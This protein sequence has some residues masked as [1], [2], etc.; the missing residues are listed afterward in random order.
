VLLASLL[1]L[2]P[3]ASDAQTATPDTVRGVIRSDSGRVILGASVFVTRSSDRALAQAVTDSAGRYQVVFAEGS[4]D[5]LVFASAPGFESARRRVVRA[6][7]ERLLTVDLVLVTTVAT[8]LAAVQVVAPP[9]PRAP[10]AQLPRGAEEVGAADRWVDGPTGLL[11]P[12]QMGTIGAMVTTAPGFVASGGAVSYLG[13]P[14][15]GNLA[16]LNG[17]ALP[18]DR[19]PRLAQYDTRAVGSSFDPTSGGFA[20]AQFEI[21]L[22]PG[23][24]MYQRRV[25]SLALEPSPVQVTDLTGRAQGLDAGNLRASMAADGELVRRAMTYNVA[26][27][28]DRRTATPATLATASP[29]VL[30]LAGLSADSAQR[31]R[32]EAAAIGL[33]VGRYAPRTRTGITWLGRIDD[34]RDPS[35]VLALTTTLSSSR[36]DGTPELLTSLPSTAS[37]DRDAS[38]SAQL[39]F[40]RYFGRERTRSFEARLAYAARR[41]EA[42]PALSVPTATVLVGA[43]IDGEV[44]VTPLTAGGFADRRDVRTQSVESWLQGSWFADGTKHRFRLQLWGRLDDERRLGATNGAGSFAYPSLAALAAN[45]PSAFSRTFGVV[46][47]RGQATNAAAAFSYRWAPTRDFS[48][49]GGTRL[50]AGA[51]GGDLA[52]NPTLESALGVRSGAPGP[53]VGLSPR[54]GFSWRPRR[55]RP[56]DVG[57]LWSELGRFVKPSTNIVRGGIGLFRGQ[58]SA[59]SAVDASLFDATGS[60]LS[61]T[62]VG[63]SVPAADWSAFA[64]DS[65]AI[66]SDCLGGGGVQAE[67]ASAVQ[68][69]ARDF[70]PPRSWRSNLHYTTALRGWLVRAEVAGARNLGLASRIDANF[71]G[72]PA[73]TLAEGGRRVWVPTTAIDSASG[74]VSSA[75]SRRDPGFA[76]VRVLRADLESRAAQATVTLTSNV[77][78]NND[79]FLSVAY[80]LQR[81]DQQFRGADGAGFGD[82]R[83]IEWARGAADARHAL[84]V[85]A[86]RDLG[87]AGRVSILVRAQSGLPFTPLVAAD[88]DGDG[89]SGDRAFVADPAADGDAERRAGMSALLA[90]APARIQRCLESQLGRVADRQSCEGPWTITSNIRWDIRVPTRLG[91]RRLGAALNIDNPAA[92]LDVALHGNRLRGWGGPAAPDP[93]LLVPTGFDATAQRFRY[94]VNPRF[95]STDPRRTLLRA[96]ARVTLDFTLDLSRDENVQTLERNL[97]PQRVNGQ[98]RRPTRDMIY[99]RYAESISSLHGYIL[100]NSDTLFLTR[101]QIER[102]ASAD[103]AFLRDARGI[104][105]ALADTLAA[106]PERR[107]PETALAIVRRAQKRYLELFYQQRAI[108]E[109]VLTPVQREILPLVRSILGERLDPDWERWPEFIFDREGRSVT[110]NRRG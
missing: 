103:T 42:A 56:V 58:Y 25:A 79:R 77:M 52:R 105:A 39:M 24:R 32:D 12:S 62:C 51:L 7:S 23:N 98:W 87:L 101:G 11:S 93:V 29:D 35:R 45:E 55:N 90:R 53:F 21:Q 57:Q 22:G 88:I 16:T 108:V 36:D 19:L 18:G 69:F 17:T 33:P 67:R 5:Y 95:G 61:L 81:V 46:D 15:D 38:G 60:T 91:G 40:Q 70:A 13:A 96:P 94:R 65:A 72:T 6:A 28:V 4:G 107:D 2:M 109:D 66:P 97:E 8:Q 78:K 64:A 14:S 37:R 86:G 1:G 10:R 68:L 75:A 110:T 104:Y 49:I 59:A 44:G 85:Q 9:P 84:I 27:D 30:A 106:L 100:T 74:A 73:F 50:E 99:R 89:V 48:M 83:R 41:R 26:L 92:G 76:R 102:L 47:A 20:G 71:A 54:L 80:T 3:R 82:P 34:T 43:E 63:A 31:F